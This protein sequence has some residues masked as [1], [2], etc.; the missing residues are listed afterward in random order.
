MQV[1]QA[2]DNTVGHHTK[3]GSNAVAKCITMYTGRFLVLSVCE[4]RGV[5]KPPG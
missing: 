4:A 1:L 2:L 3:I 5:L